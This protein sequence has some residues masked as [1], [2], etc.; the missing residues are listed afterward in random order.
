MQKKVVTRGTDVTVNA[1]YK[2]SRIKQYLKDGRALRIETVVNSPDDLRCHRRLVHLDEELAARGRAV[3]R[4]L[5]DT[6]RVGQGCASRIQPLRESRG[7][8]SP[9]MAGGPRP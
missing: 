2:S 3:N 1:F 4:R 7:P 6:E 8:P 5:L 9:T